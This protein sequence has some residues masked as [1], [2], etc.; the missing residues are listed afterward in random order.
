MADL[1]PVPTGVQIVV[2]MVKFSYS[3]GL[4]GQAAQCGDF[5]LNF[6]WD[7]N[8]PPDL[9]PGLDGEGTHLCQLGQDLTRLALR[10]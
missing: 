8:L 3:P 2:Q 7:G 4:A 5:P 1:L 9:A 10:G 6:W